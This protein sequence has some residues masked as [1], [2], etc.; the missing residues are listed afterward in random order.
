MRHN[1]LNNGALLVTKVGNFLCT[2][3]QLLYVC[4]RCS[5]IKLV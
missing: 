2:Q 4:F 1:E 3:L 5:P